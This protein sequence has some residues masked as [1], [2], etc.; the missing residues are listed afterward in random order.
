MRVYHL[1]AQ[2]LWIDEIYSLHAAR[3][4]QPLGPAELTGDIHGALYSLVLHVVGRAGEAEWILRLP[5][6]LFGTALVP[7][8][9]MLARAWVGREAV[10]PAAWLTAFSPFL[11][12]YSQEARNYM[13]LMLCVAVAA[14]AMLRLR[15][16]PALA[17]GAAWL[18]SAW[19]AL[20]SSLSFALLLPLHL[21]WW[22]AAPGPRR[23]RVVAAAVAGGLLLLLVAPWL[24]G[25]A[26]TYA[27][28][29]LRPGAPTGTRELRG[30]T[31]FHAAAIP[32]ALHAMAVGYTLGPPLRALRAGDPAGEMWRH[33][34]EVATVVAVFAPLGLLGLAALKRRGRLIDATLWMAVP[35]M[36]VSYFALRNVKVFH[37]RYL[38]VAMPAF[39]LVLAAGFA[40]ARRRWAATFA[41]GIAALWG[42]SL[43]HH[44]TVP[45]YG[46]EDSRGAARWV[47]ARGRA[48]ERVLLLGATEVVFH[49]Y[50]GP[51]RAEEFWLGFASDP[52]RLERELAAALAG[53]GGAWLILSRGEDL[54]PGDA[55]GAYLARRFPD[56][57]RSVFE[58]V[59]VWHLDGQDVARLEAAPAH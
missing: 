5:S 29:R 44:F 19:A 22:M 3:I 4:G 17:G 51:L 48:G 50:R 59:R 31:T 14:L 20:L 36:L 33:W 21:F 52:A 32:F 34:R 9:A 18:A 47:A 13:L 37:P 2:S 15:D 10:I 11:V 6:A 46:K 28:G 39:L 30:A 41:L 23:A 38:A 26:R 25:A 1:G 7:V 42:L 58:G 54:D 43:V 24:I 45:A 55:L 56:A 49:Y 53:A 8:M 12:W 16:H 35:A 27:F 57:E 40:D